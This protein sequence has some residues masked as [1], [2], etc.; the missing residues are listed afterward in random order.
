MSVRLASRW[1]SELSRR[2]GGARQRATKSV[3]AARSLS[4]AP[5]GGTGR[6]RR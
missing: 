2:A 3:Q 1:R 6:A 5:A 4:T